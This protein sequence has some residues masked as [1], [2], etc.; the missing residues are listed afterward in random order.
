[1]SEEFFGPTFEEAEESMVLPEGTYTFLVEEATGQKGKNPDKALT[2]A[3]GNED[4]YNYRLNLK[5]RVVKAPP[6]AQKYTNRVIFGRFPLLGQMSWQVRRLAQQAALD[7]IQSKFDVKHPDYDPAQRPKFSS[8]GDETWLKIC[9]FYCTGS[10]TDDTGRT[11][12]S[13]SGG[14]AGK[15]VEIVI[16]KPKKNEQTKELETGFMSPVKVA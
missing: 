10:L 3:G 15:H 12:E 7:Y 2:E 9:A 13:S 14:L 1:M 16:G 4:V 6:T 8:S 5:L 11:Y